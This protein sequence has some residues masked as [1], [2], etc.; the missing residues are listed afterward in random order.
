[1]RQAVLVE[2]K[3]IEFREVVAPQ[4]SD[5]TSHQVLINVKRIGVCGSEIH[6]YHG[7]H[8]STFYPVVQGHEYSA[9]V[10]AC[11]DAVTVCKPGDAVTARPQL[12]C[13]DCNPCK[14][15]QYN[16]CEHL[17]VQAFQ[18][19]GTAQD[20]FIVDDD[21]VVVLP[22][23][24]SLDF[25]AMIEPTAVGA[26]ATNRTDVKDKNVVVSGAGTI[27]NLVAQ[28]CVARGAKNVL[29][30]D[31]SD[32]RLAKAKECGIPH[33]VNVAKKSLKEAA[34]EIFGDEGYQVGFEVA[35][36]ESSIR[37]IMESIE[38]GSDIVVVAV[39]ANDPAL[40][41]FFLGEHE[42]RLIGTLMYRHEDYLTA[43]DFVNRGVIHLES[44]IS[45]R[46][47]FEHYDEA[48]QFIDANREK[49]MKVI[50]DMEM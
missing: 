43:I 38:K 25:G 3:H 49:T 17:R 14:R 5:L 45:N 1:M 36:V 48:Y 28:F 40:S 16:V 2:P 33:T 7:Q 20:Y 46:F 6:S 8:P 21:R 47:A 39:F 11:G 15:G 24:M 26:H 22:E 4:P 41:M 18:A 31:I 30:T 13:G 9:V 32:F 12:I 37:S 10:V 27:G 44:L 50:I 19:D 29:I 23:G 34:K 35:G 42:L